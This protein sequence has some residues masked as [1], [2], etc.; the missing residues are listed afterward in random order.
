MLGGLVFV[1]CV[2]MQ[3]HYHEPIPW[4]IWVPATIGLLASFGE[5]AIRSAKK[6]ITA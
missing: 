2:I 4:Y 1:V 3:F 6:A 5:P